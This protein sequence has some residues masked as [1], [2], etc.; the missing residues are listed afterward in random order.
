[1]LCRTH[2]EFTLSPAE[3]RARLA[4][5]KKSVQLALDR[6]KCQDD[7]HFTVYAHSADGRPLRKDIELIVEDR[8]TGED[9]PVFLR[10]LSDLS[11][12]VGTRARLLVEIRSFTSL[13]VF[14][15]IS[16]YFGI[17][18]YLNFYIYLY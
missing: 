11:V 13:K 12:K 18:F 15:F 4:E 6:L 16:Q 3:K 8:S 17:C 9:P 10:S 14:E 1:M 5:S 2:S 7:T